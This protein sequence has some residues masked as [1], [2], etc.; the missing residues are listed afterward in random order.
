MYGA[1]CVQNGGVAELECMQSDGILYK[2]MSV[3]W[4][5]GDDVLVGR[6]T[7]YIN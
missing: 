7:V 2:R 5:R 6:V 1:G 3:Q 4:R